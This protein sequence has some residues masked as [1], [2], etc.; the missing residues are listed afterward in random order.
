MIK[1]K[2][3]LHYLHSVKASQRTLDLGGD[4]ARRGITLVFTHHEESKRGVFL[5]M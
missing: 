4:R 1:I 2:E 5:Y 3:N